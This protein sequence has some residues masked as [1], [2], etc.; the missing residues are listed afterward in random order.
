VLEDGDSRPVWTRPRRARDSLLVSMLGVTLAHEF[1]HLLLGTPGHTRQGMLQRAIPLRDLQHPT[2]ARLGLTG[3]QQL[4]LCA[5]KE[6]YTRDLS[7]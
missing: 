3:E 2:A 4:V 7:R 5:S 6:N 1:G